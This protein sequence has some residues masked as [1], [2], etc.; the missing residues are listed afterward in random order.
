M[1]IRGVA[2]RDIRE[3]LNSLIVPFGKAMVYCTG[4]SGKIVFFLRIFQIFRPLPRQHWTGI[5]RWDNSPPYH[6]G[7]TAH[8]KISS[9]PTHTLCF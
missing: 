1:K 4:C 8:I 3:Y 6:Q 9:S 5:D 2:K 7:V